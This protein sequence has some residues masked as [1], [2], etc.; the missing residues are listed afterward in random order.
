MTM[1]ARSP[2]WRTYR[3]LNLRYEQGLS[4][5][6]AVAQLREIYGDN[7]FPE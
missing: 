2:A 3:I 7:E 4:Q 6:E 5:S 1:S